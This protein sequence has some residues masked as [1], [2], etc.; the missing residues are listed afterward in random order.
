MRRSPLSAVLGLAVLLLAGCATGAPGDW[1]TTS[2]SEPSKDGA[3]F[4]VVTEPVEVR[5]HLLRHAEGVLNAKGVL[6]G[7]ADGPLTPQGAEQA[8]LAGAALADVPF[9]AAWSSDMVRTRDTAAGVLA[10]HPDAP[11]VQEHPTL[12]EWH[13]GGFEGDSLAEA[14]AAF[15]AGTPTGA[16]GEPQPVTAVADQVAAADPWGIAEDRAQVELRATQALDLVLADAMTRGGGDV[17]VVTHGMT[18][19]TMLAVVDP[20]VAAG[21]PEN[22]ALSRLTWRDGVWLAG[23]QNDLTYLGVAPG[24]E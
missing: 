3:G 7:W 22:V 9:V 12:R 1:S 8:A 10:A 6:G 4:T 21:T 18:M 14:A 5:L 15:T 23:P 17:L 2:A 19:L 20:T 13:F 24:S 16:A 11:P